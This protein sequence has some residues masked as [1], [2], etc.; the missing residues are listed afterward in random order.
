[1]KTIRSIVIIAL[2]IV[3]P[4]LFGA[5]ATKPTTP[6][7]TESLIDECA[8]AMGGFE[9]IDSLQTMR[10]SQYLPDHGGIS[11][12][13]IK[14]LNLVRLGDQVAFDGERAF[15]LT[16]DD[17]IPQEEWQDF[18]VDIAWYIPAFFDYP[19]EYLGTEV[20]DD[21]ETQKL[22]VALPLGAVMTYYL[23]AET[24][25]IYK[26]VANFTINGTEY[27]PERTYRDYQLSGGIIYPHA[28]TYE[29]RD[30]VFTATFLNIEFN[31]PL[32]DER[33]SDPWATD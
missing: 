24:H 14:R 12:Y 18:E 20:V 4:L 30:G 6:T 9:K 10:F 31:I 17:P 26:A 7:T 16:K 3:V 2:C 29:G 21:I 19:A 8:T 32:E 22:Q 33:F 11:K 23:D 13:E 25:L 15:W 28:F 1:M 5:C 27:H